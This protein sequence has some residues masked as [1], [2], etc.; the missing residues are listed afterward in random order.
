[1]QASERGG[2]IDGFLAN[3]RLKPSLVTIEGASASRVL[4]SRFHHLVPGQG[5]QETCMTLVH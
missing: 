5:P 3:M 1:M 2:D 4:I